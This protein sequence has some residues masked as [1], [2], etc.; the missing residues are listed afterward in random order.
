MKENNTRRSARIEV[1]IAKTLFIM[2]IVFLLSMLPTTSMVLWGLLDPS[3]ID[4]ENF[5]K[6]KLYRQFYHISTV[7]VLY[8]SFWNYFIY[9]TSDKEFKKSLMKLK[10]RVMEKFRKIGKGGVVKIDKNVKLNEN[11]SSKTVVTEL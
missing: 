5:K 8:N 1:R 6:H 10:K 3:A 11:L 7:V 2:V 4:T 9:Q